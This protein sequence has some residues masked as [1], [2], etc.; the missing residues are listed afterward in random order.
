MHC[1]SSTDIG[2]IIRATLSRVTSS[3]APEAA[4]ADQVR[5]PTS[6][7]MKEIEELCASAAQ[8][9]D[10]LKAETDDRPARLKALRDEIKD[11]MLKHG[12]RDVVI[13]GRPPIELAESNSR[14]PTR[15]AIV[16]VYVKDAISKLTE[17]QQRD[18]KLKKKAEQEGK[19]LA[20]NLWN[21]IEP[22]TSFSVKIPD[23]APTEMESP[24]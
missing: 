22:S 11:R 13:A 1:V 17:E 24:Y 21:A 5:P 7:E 15:K 9:Q 10:E 12:L 18:P 4:I 14:K 23:P 16:D 8:L 2:D 19:R 6:E 3:D 20:L